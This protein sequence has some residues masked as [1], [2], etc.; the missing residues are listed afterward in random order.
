MILEV[1]AQSLYS[2]EIA[3]AAGA[4]RIEFCS[5]L[6]L[7]GLTPSA[8][9]LMMARERLNLSICVLIRPR[10]GDFIYSDLEFELILKDIKVCADLGMDGIVVGALMPDGRFNLNQMK[11]LRDSA[12][13]MEV[14]S[15]RAFDATPDPFEA[16]ETLVSLG[17]HR[18][19]TSGQANTALEGM[20]LLKQ[21]ITA[22]H[23]HIEI[24]PGSGVL[25]N[26]IKT[27]ADAT[28]ATAF[29]SSF[30]KAIKSPSHIVEKE[31]VYSRNHDYWETDYEQVKAAMAILKQF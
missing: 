18:I 13:D 4:Q 12:G 5:A 10:T 2:A 31:N 15:H 16:L 21:L 14:I 29:H 6:E 20:P 7:G 3:E 22:A 26:N 23:G 27:L 11:R 30:K 19:L 17:F 9:N 28:G 25:A 24:M 1:C 8:A